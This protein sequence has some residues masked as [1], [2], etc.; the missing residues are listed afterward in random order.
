M[1]PEN[2]PSSLTIPVASAPLDLLPTASEKAFLGSSVRTG[3]PTSNPCSGT[4]RST[5][6]TP[7]RRNHYERR[8]QIYLVRQFRRLVDPL[9]ASLIAIENGEDRSPETLELLDAMGLEAGITDLVLLATGAR[10]HW[11]EIKLAKTDLHAATDVRPNQQVIHNLLRYYR[12]QVSVVRTADEFWAIVDAMQIHH[13]PRPPVHEQ[14]H[15]P[16][17]RRRRLK[18]PTAE[19]A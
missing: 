5:I 14:L 16:V 6:Q 2:A 11:I 7:R 12:F 19:A 15:L 9:D 18:R 4:V 17:M 1:S 3:K 10:A 13:L 8:L